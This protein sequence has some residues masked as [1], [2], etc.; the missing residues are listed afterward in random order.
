[1][2]AHWHGQMWNGSELGRAMGVADTTVR[3]WLDVLSGTY[4]V[5]VLPPFF[6]NL[7]KRQIK[8]PKIYIEDSG[9]LHA[10]LGLRSRDEV[11][12][13]P[14]VGAAWDGFA[15]QAVLAHVGA[16]SREAF[17]WGTPA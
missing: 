1:M 16:T 14:K 2:L 4:V 10:L 13:Y 17:F 11:L 5:R 3:R 15:L 7:A 8:S 9:L 6:E 12:R